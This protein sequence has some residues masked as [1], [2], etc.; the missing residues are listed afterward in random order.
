M[1][2][3]CRLQSDWGIR[4]RATHAVIPL[5]RAYIR[6]APLRA[7]K[8]AFWERFV[9]PRLAWHS[10]SFTARTRFGARLSGRTDEILQQYIYYFGLWEPDITRL[11]RQRLRPSDAFV[12]VGAN[13]GYYTL[14]GSRLVGESGT[15]IAIEPSPELFTV[16]QA[17]ISLNGAANVRAVNIAAADRPGRLPLFR[18][19]S[20][21]T[22]LATVVPDQGLE[23]DRLVEAQP[24]ST[25][26][27]PDELKDV[28]LVKIDVEGGEAEVVA[29]MEPLLRSGRDDL[30]VIVELHP[31]Q[32]GPEG[33]ERVLAIFRDAGFDAY[34]LENDY[35]P[36]AYLEA[37]RPSAPQ[38]VHGP[39]EHECNLIFTRQRP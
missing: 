1:S 21:N 15:V 9:F 14:L 25:L 20:E 13:A 7:G 11:V 16:L 19:P 35:S 4:H 3:R 17:N 37:A 12:D 26:L 6:Y 2:D 5:A 32:L 18:G 30:E 23:F 39:I 27:H 8:L 38:P 10:H 34:L 22:G 24:L 31:E 28:R 36:A 29:G 33:S